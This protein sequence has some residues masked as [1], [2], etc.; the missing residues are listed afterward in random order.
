MTL[1]TFLLIACVIAIALC[2]W[3]IRALSRDN[4]ELTASLGVTDGNLARSRRRCKRLERMVCE[5]DAAV[6]RMN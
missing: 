3:Y 5:R 2:G 4:L 1:T 6:A